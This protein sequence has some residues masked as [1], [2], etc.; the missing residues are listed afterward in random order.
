MPCFGWV[1]G[2]M[3]SINQWSALISRESFQAV[4]VMVS[5][6]EARCT[7]RYVVPT[8]FIA[9]L[10]HRLFDRIDFSSLRTGIMAGSVCPEPLMKRVIEKMNLR[11]I[12]NVYGLTEASPGMTQT[13]KDEEFKRR[14]STVGRAMPGEEVPVAEPETCPAGS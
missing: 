10:E 3:A 5:D 11:E 1:R 2:G 12:T 4:D 6:G 7:G 9:V 8:R 14:G 13:H